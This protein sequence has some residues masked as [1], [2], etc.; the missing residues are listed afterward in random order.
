MFSVNIDKLVTMTSNEKKSYEELVETITGKIGNKATVAVTGGGLKTFKLAYTYLKNGKKVLFI[1]GD[2]SSD[3]FLG[4]YKLGKNMHGLTDFIKTPD[5]NHDMICFT[6]EPNLN[7]IFTGALD[8]GF[9]SAE[10][11]AAMKK[12]IEKY[13]A[14]YDVLVFDSDKDGKIAKYCDGTVV[15]YDESEF[16]EIAAQKQVDD[17]TGMGCNVLGVVICE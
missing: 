4:K 3:I 1:D 14:E 8:D 13:N 9:V 16:G 7:I 12:L 11:E 10:E 15:I 6:N 2:I 17:L 5:E